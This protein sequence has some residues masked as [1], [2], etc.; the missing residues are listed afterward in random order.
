MG[1]RKALKHLIPRRHG[2]RN[3]DPYPDNGSGSAQAPVP[4]DSGSLSPLPT[5]S[6]G[7]L[8]S[9]DPRLPQPGSGLEPPS[10]GTFVSAPGPT[11]SAGPPHPQATLS[12]LGAKTWLWTRAYEALRVQDAQLVDQYERLLSRELE[13]HSSSNA[14]LENTENRIDTNPD[15]RRAQL[16]KIT[17]Q[18]LRRMD[19]NQTKY[20]ISGHVFVVRD[21]ATQAIKLIQMFKGLVDEAVKASPE[22][23]IAWAGVCILLPVLTKPEAAAAANS[24]GLT[25]VTSRIRYYIELESL[26]LPEKLEKPGLKAEFECRIV[27]LYQCILE[28]QLKTVLRLYRKWL[29]TLGRDLISHDDW[30]AM[31]LKIKDLEKD[32]YSESIRINTLSSRSTLENIWDGA[33]EQHSKM[34]R[35]LHSLLLTAED[36]VAEQRRTN[37]ILENHPINLPTVPEAQYNSADVQDSPKCEAGTRVCI[38]ET[39]AQWADE[40]IGESFFWLVGPAG[41]GK[42]TIA[43]TVAHNFQE[44][45]RLAAGY[46][47]KRGEQGRN[48]TSRFFTTL[49]AQLAEAIPA[50][51]SY[52]QRSLHGLENDSVAKLSLEAQFDKLFPQMDLPSSDTHPGSKVV[53]IDALDECERP[54]HL[55]KIVGLLSKLC[56]VTWARLRVLF[57][58]RSDPSIVSVFDRLLRKHFARRLDLRQEFAEDTKEDIRKVLEARFSHLKSNGLVE[59]DPWPAA[60]DFDRLVQM[61]TNPEPLFIYAATFCRFV[62][63]EQHPKDPVEQLRLWLEQREASASQIQQIYDPI[64]NQA[65]RGSDEVELLQRLQFLGALVL[66][67]TP[68]PAS[69]LAALLGMTRVKW[70]LREFHAVLDVPGESDRPTRLLH[71]SFSDYLLSSDVSNTGLYRVDAAEIQTLLAKR[72]IQR[73]ATGLKQDICDIRK[74]DAAQNDV[75]KATINRCIPSELQY[76]CRHWVDHL[77]R[78][79][80]PFNKEISNFLYEHLLHWLEAMCLLGNLREGANVMR[81]LL[82]FTQQHDN[83]PSEFIDF[84][85][86]ANRVISSFGSIIER[87]PLQIYGSLLLFAPVAS[88]VRQRFWDQRLPSLCDIQGVKPDWDAHRQTLEGHTNNITAIAFS[89]DGRLLASGSRDDTVRLWDAITGTHLQTLE[90]HGSPVNAVAFSPDGQILASGS[91]SKTIRIWNVPTGAPLKTLESDSAWVGVVAFSLDSEWLASASEESIQVWNLNTGTERRETFLIDGFDAIAFSPDMRLASI[92]FG[93]TIQLANIATGRHQYVLTGH[94]AP[95]RSIAFSPDGNFIASGSDDHTVRLWNTGDGTQKSKID[96]HGNAVIAVAFSPNGQLLTSA[97]SRTVKIWDTATGTQQS[98]LVH[99]GPKIRT[100]AF[101]P[102]SQD[103][104]ITVSNRDTTIQ[105]LENRQV[106]PEKN[107]DQHESV[108]AMVLS[109]DGQLVAAASRD[110]TVRLWDTSTWSSRR[111][112]GDDNYDVLQVTFSPDSKQLAS[113]HDS[114]WGD[115]TWI[116]DVENGTNKQT[117]DDDNGLVRAVAYSPDGQLVASGVSDTLKVYE[118]MTG[119]CLYTLE[120]HGGLI[121]A[122]VFSH[123]SQSLA[124]WSEDETIRL[125]DMETGLSR[126][127]IRVSS[128][129]VQSKLLFSPDSKLIALI[130][131]DRGMGC[132]DKATG[133]QHWKFH[134][135]V[136]N[137]ANGSV[138]A[139]AFSPNNRLLATVKRDSHDRYIIELGDVTTRCGCSKELFSPKND[140]TDLLFSPDC[141][142]VAAV[143][144]RRFICVWNTT[145]YSHLYTLPIPDGIIRKIR[146]SPDGKTIA[147]ASTSKTIRLWEANTGAHL[148]TIHHSKG[149]VRE[150]RFFHNELVASVSDE[151]EDYAWNLWSP[152]ALEFHR[153]DITSALQKATISEPIFDGVSLDA[154]EEWITS[155][156]EKVIWLPPEYRPTNTADEKKPHFRRRFRSIAW[157]S[158]ETTIFIGC[159]SGRAIRVQVG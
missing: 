21:Q 114:R 85:K 143:S 78:S 137:G 106:T 13:P 152:M 60:E 129:H 5:T 28:F 136:R 74:L 24:E 33:K 146:F 16:E 157:T 131:Q 84:V 144:R 110:K 126:H 9:V 71:K 87:V 101:S 52:L 105:L 19:E 48:D 8:P 86:D 4:P 135:M 88:K 7:P 91:W 27:E 130:G 94:H 120:D 17:D 118:A 54:D 147:S 61:A 95:I 11:L 89:P 103:L 32:V 30:K 68:L 44:E 38:Q 98:T 104:A 141:R 112:D 46:F 81:G 20:T 18:G 26:L 3:V 25:Y 6:P 119:V 43:R 42:S 117:F 77:Q 113:F 65:F 142:L 107:R 83:V 156:S 62:F 23:A 151:V 40:K 73:M 127:V 153:Y 36:M 69:S 125:W 35:T 1:F 72:C 51:Q 14:D 140:Y 58:S 124:S 132:W 116:W 49:A 149:L 93:V 148:Q 37:A 56:N 34:Q 80:E 50:L 12:P 134:D 92:G 159:A 10:S 82:N 109:P 133:A 90:G 45:G 99:D 55:Q 47:F 66:L 121:G 158:R 76:A 67:A 100:I 123:D 57:T 108:R 29:A 63:D 128:S 53:I 39:I 31:L 59:D 138:S 2:R 102:D 22:A 70:W 155:G 115:S 64:L 75:E 96:G 139:A 145:T 79:E 41:T 97:S 15:D 154:D 122:I 111:M 150:M